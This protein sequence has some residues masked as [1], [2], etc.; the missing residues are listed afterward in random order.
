MNNTYHTLLS[1]FTEDNY[2]TNFIKETIASTLRV[3]NIFNLEIFLI[4][5][6]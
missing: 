4:Y 6:E 1:K 5:I 2:S 3:R